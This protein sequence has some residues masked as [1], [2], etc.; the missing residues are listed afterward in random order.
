M[1]EKSEFNPDRYKKVTTEEWQRAA[2]G[3]HKWIPFISEL[4]K[5][6]TNKMLDLAHVQSGHRVLDI[7]AGDGDQSI[8]A[9][10]R[11]GAGGYVLATDISSNLLAYAKKA[12]EEAELNNFETRLMDGENLELEDS[13]FDSAICRQG[14]MLM[15]NAQQAVNEI[16]RVLRSGGWLSTIVFSTPDKNPWISIPA[17][18][19]MKYAQLPPPKPGMPGLFSLS[20]PGVLEGILKT[21]GFQDIQT[22]YQA[23]TIQLSSAAEC[24]EFLQDIAGALHTILANV[25]A[26]EQKKAW[27]EME[28]ALKKFENSQGFL[29]PVETIVVAGKKP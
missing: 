26:D 27:A 28:Q 24:V 11:V 9:A 17:M 13:T 15:P 12:A 14:L 1:S 4:F 25:S 5:A 3:W 29:S 16:Y 19:A 20:S 2:T 22:H 10:K 8:M 6:A 18:I 21:S 23:G 7:A